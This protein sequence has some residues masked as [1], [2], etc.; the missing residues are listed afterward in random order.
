[1]AIDT[2]YANLSCVSLA[3]S[4]PWY[5]KLFGK[6]PTRRPMDGLA[7]W[8]IT[9]SAQVQLHENK[10]H[11]GKSTMTVGVDAIEPER[12]RLAGL[13]LD[14]GPV[15]PAKDFFILRLHDPDGNLVVLASARRS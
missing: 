8:Q 1:M 6:P 7:E 9:A 12:S 4:E 13:G 10:A 11:A 5:G 2:I 14:P 3:A 15:E